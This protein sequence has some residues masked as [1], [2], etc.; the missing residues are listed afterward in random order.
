[1]LDG[2][3]VRKLSELKKHFNI[4]DMLEHYISGLLCQWLLLRKAVGWR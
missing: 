3:K 1:M 4:D 2:Q